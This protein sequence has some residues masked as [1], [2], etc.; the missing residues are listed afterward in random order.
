M[1]LGYGMATGKYT[2]AGSVTLVNNEDGGPG[3]GILTIAAS[4]ECFSTSL[5]THILTFTLQ[6]NVFQDICFVPRICM[7]ML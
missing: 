2:P 5:V 3:S 7:N 1:E 4:Y 6:S